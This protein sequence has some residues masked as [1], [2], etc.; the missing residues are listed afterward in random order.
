MGEDESQAMRDLDQ[1]RRSLFSI[2]AL[3]PEQ[4]TLRFVIRF[5]FV[6]LVRRSI[7]QNRFSN[8]TS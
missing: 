6:N 3:L 8:P 7:I 2:G 1:S 4:R 5:D